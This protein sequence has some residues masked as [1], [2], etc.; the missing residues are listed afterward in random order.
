MT[1]LRQITAIL[2]QIISNKT[3][4]ENQSNKTYVENQKQQNRYKTVLFVYLIKQT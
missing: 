3:Y 4:V 2:R 1:N